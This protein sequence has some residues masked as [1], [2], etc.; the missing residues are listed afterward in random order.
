[1]KLPEADVMGLL[2]VVVAVPV[3]LSWLIQ[4]VS[5]TVKLVDEALP[6]LELPTRLNVPFTIRLFKVVSPET[7]SVPPIVVLPDKDVAPETERVLKVPPDLTV[8]LPLI[9]ALFAKLK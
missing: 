9:S 3:T 1:M 2:K 5:E 6:K 7:F 8:K 4:P